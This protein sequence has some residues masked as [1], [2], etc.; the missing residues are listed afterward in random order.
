M[1]EATTLRDLLRS[2]PFIA[3]QPEAVIDTLAAK[4]EL[5]RELA[6]PEA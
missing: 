4:A 5:L 1:A 6:T 2:F 3:D